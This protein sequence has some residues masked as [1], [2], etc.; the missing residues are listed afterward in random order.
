MTPPSG[1][2]IAT[3]P[4][5]TSG[6]IQGFFPGGRPTILQASPGRAAPLRPQAPGP[7]QAGQIS[8]PAPVA[9]G[10]GGLQPKLRPFEATGPILATDR[11]QGALKPSAAP[12]PQPPQPVLPRAVLPAPLQPKAGN[13]FAL[14]ASFT[15]KPRGSGQ[16][17]PEP[18]QK[19]MES[20]F[21]TSF[22]DVRVHV[23]HEAPS[24]GAL[25]FAHGTD[26]ISP[27]YEGKLDIEKEYCIF[28]AGGK[29][30]DFV[31]HVHW[32]TIG[33]HMYIAASHFKWLS[34]SHGE[35]AATVSRIDLQEVKLPLEGNETFS[36]T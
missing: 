30:T 23:G 8:P 17:L 15:L 13:A 18:I 14:P 36:A 31:V 21:N 32:K 34:D 6:V 29:L 27:L 19:K 11:R 5:M 28:E 35:K 24:I 2:T 33:N 10:P 16:P 3:R 1:P 12:R 20:L 7:V 25:A 4:G 26:S 22:A 9:P